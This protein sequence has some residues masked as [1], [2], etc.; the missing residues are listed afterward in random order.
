MPKD[1]QSPAF[2]F[3][4]RDFASNGEVEAMTT[5]EVGA[6]IL[7]LCKAWFQNPPASIPNNDAVLARWARL[8]PEAWEK[9]KAGVLAAFTLGTDDRWHQ[10]RLRKEFEK[11][12]SSKKRRVAA[13]KIAAK[14]RWEDSQNQQDNANRIAN[15]P[16]NASQSQANGNAITM[17]SDAIAFASAKKKT[18]NVGAN[19]PKQ[20]SSTAD[21][22]SS[23]PAIQAV[24]E[25]TGQ[26]PNK[27]NYD[28]IIE[29]LGDEPDKAKLKDCATAWGKVSKNIFNLVWVFEWYP[30]GIPK[31]KAQQQAAMNQGGTGNPVY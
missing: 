27:L 8:T 11:L 3:Y 6:Y 31:P 21:P 18:T 22:R 15:A 7:L 10:T 13:A 12:Q 24:K 25:I 30:N 26:Y 1:D 4:P 17:P 14:Q 20:K 23:H 19:A 2:L 29:T 5:E 28:E 16:P 9:C